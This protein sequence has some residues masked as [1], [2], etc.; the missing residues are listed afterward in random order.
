MN[1]LIEIRNKK[2][3]EYLQKIRTEELF[4]KLKSYLEFDP[5]KRKCYILASFFRKYYIK[6]YENSV[7]ISLQFTN[8]STIPGFK[9]KHIVNLF[10]KKVVNILVFDLTEFHFIKANIPKKYHKK[11]LLDLKKVNNLSYEQNFHY[12][13]CIYQD[14]R[15]HIN[16]IQN[17]NIIKLINLKI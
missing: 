14:N 6:K 2:H 7:L 17:E 9:R 1:Q 15:N 12:L 11:I 10:R 16:K 13:K 5:F 8:V 4:E 3:N